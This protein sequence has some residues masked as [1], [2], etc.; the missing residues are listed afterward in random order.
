MN[1]ISTFKQIVFFVLVISL[2]YI[3]IL[4]TCKNSIESSK[5]SIPTIILVSIIISLCLY[6]Y[7]N[8]VKPF[9]YSSQGYNY[10]KLSSEDKSQLNISPG[11]L[12]RGGAYTW[13]GDS[14][15]AKM[16]RD[17]ASTQEGRDSI[18]N[19]ECDVGYTGVPKSDFQFTP[20]SNSNWKN[21]RC[22]DCT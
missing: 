18:N 2:Y 11:K 8:L 12:C 4:F 15:R 20:I 6:G 22:S 14:T 13:Q 1:I 16:C 21:E 7:L 5:V 19:F 17:M 10:S 3:S 9:T